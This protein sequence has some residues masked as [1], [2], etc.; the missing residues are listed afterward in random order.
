MLPFGFNER[1][2]TI[3]YNCFPL[4][5]IYS[6]SLEIIVKHSN[7]INSDN[8]NNNTCTTIILKPSHDKR[9]YKHYTL[10]SLTIRTDINQFYLIYYFVGQQ[11][12]DIFNI[13]DRIKK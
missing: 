10:P 3:I 11:N 13:F 4:S 5:L 9:T 6:N 7:F 1:F 12:D 2:L 8:I